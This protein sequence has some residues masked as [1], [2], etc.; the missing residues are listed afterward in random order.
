MKSYQKVAAHYMNMFGL[1]E[2]WDS[3]V[4]Y[5]PDDPTNLNHLYW[6]CNGIYMDKLSS[7]TKS[8]RWL[9]YVQGVLVMKGLLD[10]NEERD[11]T[12]ETFN[13]E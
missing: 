4:E 1:D 3:I 11:R 12:R 9:G 6:M 5:T 13:G 10:V 2:D 8:H 7:E